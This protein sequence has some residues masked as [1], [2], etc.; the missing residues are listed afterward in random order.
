MTKRANW[1][2]VVALAFCIGW[3]VSDLI[4]TDTPAFNTEAQA[5]IEQFTDPTRPERQMFITESE[6]GRTLVWWEFKPSAGD[7][8]EMRRT[9]IFEAG[10]YNIPQN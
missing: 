9:R 4:D 7:L 1:I 8:P 6:D 2:L 5:S 3:I 10:T